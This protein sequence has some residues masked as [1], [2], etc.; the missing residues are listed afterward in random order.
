MHQTVRFICFLGHKKINKPGQKEAPYPET[1]T[2]QIDSNILAKL[3]IHFRLDETKHIVVNY[4]DIS[5][6]SGLNI[7]SITTLGIIL[8][9]NWNVNL[10]KIANAIRLFTF[11]PLLVLATNIRSRSHMINT[12]THMIVDCITR[13]RLLSFLNVAP[14]KMR[15]RARWPESVSSLYLHLL[16]Q[17]YHSR[18]LSENIP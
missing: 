7:L 17:F 12:N 10:Y 6:N 2:Y 3:Q 4:S 16:C 1:I 13:H 8:S 9:P 5:F 11:S 15:I 14:S 18:V